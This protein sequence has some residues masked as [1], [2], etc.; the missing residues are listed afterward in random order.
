MKKKGVTLIELI[1]V[2]ALLVIVIPLAFN[3]YLNES[4]IANHI[5]TNVN[6]Q[7]AG[8][9]AINEINRDFRLAK[10]I[11]TNYDEIDKDFSALNVSNGS[12][13]TTIM[14]NRIT[15][16]SL[17]YI[18][19]LTSSNA[20]IY[21]TTKI[22]PNSTGDENIY[23]FYLNQVPSNGI[24]G[25]YML[26]ASSI[27][28]ITD[29]TSVSYFKVSTIDDFENN[30]VNK[31]SFSLTRNSIIIENITGIDTSYNSNDDFLVLGCFIDPNNNNDK[32]AYF[33]ND[34]SGDKYYGK[35]TSTL[36]D[37]HVPQCTV[38][39]QKTIIEA[40]NNFNITGSAITYNI[41]FNLKGSDNKDYPFNVD[42]NPLYLGGGD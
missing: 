35:L 21:A 34:V 1:V 3:I 8:G 14:V 7:L 12:N 2:I 31:N 33:M 15:Y 41:K 29:D 42:V 16:R 4:K 36:Q 39:S 23:K 24:I 38:S 30:I 5:S 22:I 25:K 28:K 40:A 18:E 37:Y 32:Y 19:S 11:C 13:G 6:A 9:D 10:R 27:N 26:E 17:Y 20:F